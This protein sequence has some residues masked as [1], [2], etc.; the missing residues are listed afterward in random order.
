MTV[1]P[2]W[3]CLHLISVHEIVVLSG[4]FM[5]IGWFSVQHLVTITTVATDNPCKGGNRQLCSLNFS[6]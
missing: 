6:I 2:H 1:R 3:P 5:G 4:F